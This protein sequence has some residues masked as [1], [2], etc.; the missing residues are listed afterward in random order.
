MRVSSHSASSR[1][2]PPKAAAAPASCQPAHPS[3][4]VSTTRRLVRVKLA[5]PRAWCRRHRGRGRARLASS[6]PV[7]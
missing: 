5:G 6:A 7:M 3:T 1:L 2:A 4:N